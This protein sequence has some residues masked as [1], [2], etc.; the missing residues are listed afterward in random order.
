MVSHVTDDRFRFLPSLV[1]VS[2]RLGGRPSK[3][4]VRRTRYQLNNINQCQHAHLVIC[5][6]NFLFKIHLF[7]WRTTSGKFVQLILINRP[8]SIGIC[9]IDMR[10]NAWITPHYPQR[11]KDFDEFLDRRARWPNVTFWAPPSGPP[12]WGAKWKLNLT[13]NRAFCVKSQRRKCDGRNSSFS[14]SSSSYS[15]SPTSSI[16][17]S[18]EG[19]L[20]LSA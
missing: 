19:C 12:L 8:I 17:K 9:P 10:P 13:A 20:S 15:P 5:P 2:E 1:N 6:I 3:T 11:V 4:K 18:S 7:H 16:S 14:P